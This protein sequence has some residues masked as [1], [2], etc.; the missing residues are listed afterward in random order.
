MEGTR[1]PE[2]CEIMWKNYLSFDVNKEPFSEEED[3]KLW[4]LAQDHDER[5]WDEIA[6][7]LKVC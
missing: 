4:Y 5:N 6:T 1:S 2:E 7:S 3:N